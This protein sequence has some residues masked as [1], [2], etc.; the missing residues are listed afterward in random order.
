MTNSESGD[1]GEP[2]APTGNQ[3]WPEGEHPIT[4]LMAPVQGASSP[5]GE[6]EFPLPAAELGY[7]HPR[8]QINR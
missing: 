7:E 2:G 5:F 3:W 1:A 6:A 8:T 4:E